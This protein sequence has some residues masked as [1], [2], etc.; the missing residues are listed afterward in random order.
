MTAEKIPKNN[1][2]AS[3]VFLHK[4]QNGD[5]S[6][7]TI[8]LDEENCD[9]V[10]NDDHGEDESQQILSPVV[11]KK[12]RYSIRVSG[13]NSNQNGSGKGA[14]ERKAHTMNCLRKNQK[15][16]ADNSDNVEIACELRR[17]A[18][19]RKCKYKFGL[20]EWNK[21]IESQTIGKESKKQSDELQTNANARVEQR[22]DK[23]QH[24]QRK[25][26]HNYIGKISARKNSQQTWHTSRKWTI[27]NTPRLEN[28]IRKKVF[29]FTF[30]QSQSESER[31]FEKQNKNADVDLDTQNITI[32]YNSNVESLTKDCTE[33]QHE[34][35][36]D[37]RLNQVNIQSSRKRKIRQFI[38]VTP[39]KL[40]KGK[41][42]STESLSTAR[43]LSDG[44]D[45]KMEKKDT[46]NSMVSQ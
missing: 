37:E 42:S 6:E 34:T 40:F 33:I 24:H 15:G 27:Q 1:G 30:T 38:N 22:I 31:V 19:K 5:K 43:S 14:K 20:D 28:R 3:K 35:E 32:A 18:R 21:D 36:D 4:K 16:T 13:S 23:V 17:S 12:R 25:V 45:E 10:G 26:K 44:D 7:V 39:T 41:R 8:L 2:F 11:L 46:E 29:A 9:F